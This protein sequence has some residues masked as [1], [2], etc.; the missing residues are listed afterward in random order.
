MKSPLGMRRQPGYN[1]RTRF[2]YAA[3]FSPNCI[4]SVECL[5]GQVAPVDRRAFSAGTVEARLFQINVLVNQTTCVA[6]CLLGFALTITTG[7]PGSRLPSSAWP[8]SRK[9]IMANHSKIHT[10]YVN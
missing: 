7:K 8:G 2:D 5:T 3:G 10:P 1:R 9:M 4:E 6:Y